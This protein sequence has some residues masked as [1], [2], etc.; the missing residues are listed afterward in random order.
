MKRKRIFA[1]LLV[2]T[3]LVSMLAGCGKGKDTKSS[4]DGT[5]IL[6]MLLGAVK[7]D[8][9]LKQVGEEAVLFFPGLPEGSTITLYSGNGYFADEVVMI[10]VK[11]VSQTKDAADVIKAHQ[12]EL[13]KQFMNYIPEEVPKIE[14]AK[15]YTVDNNVFSCITSDSKTVQTIFDDPAAFKENFSGNINA[16]A[17]SGSSD[18]PDASTP[19]SD[20]GAE[21]SVPETTAPQTHDYPVLKSE[22]GTYHDYG[23]SAYTIR[24]DNKAYELFGFDSANAAVYADLVSKTADA[25]KGKVNVYAMPIPTAIGITL[26]DD[27]WKDFQVATHQGV[28]IETVLGKMSSNVIPV[29]VYDNMMLH[30]DE[31]LYFHTDYHWNGR[32]AYYAY[33]TFCKTK[34][35]TPVTLSERVEKQFPGFLGVLYQNN[36]SQDPVLK[37]NPDTVYAYC[38]KA[39]NI[40]MEYTDSKGETHPW[41]IITDVSDWAASSKYNTFAGGDNPISVF[42]NPGVTDNSVC[43]VVKDSYGNALLPLLVDHYSTIYEI[44]FR[45]WSGDLISFAQEKGATDMLFA[46]NMMNICSST[47]NGWLAKIINA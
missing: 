43:I 34:G 45:Y 15:T 11:N 16:S 33:E 19:S 28:D 47:P 18:I 13:K 4:V 30:R 14:G 35:M 40:S 44:D 46:L 38:P 26:P 27:L 21:A 37:E 24:V 8:T 6:N 1:A 20:S 5:E 39:T 23:A 42:K 41:Q 32:G 22:S 9:E 7:Y 17:P 36:S 10:T 2:V 3:L 12:E 29:N 31:Y 25:L